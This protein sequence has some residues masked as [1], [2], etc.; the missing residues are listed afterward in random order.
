M[1][2][3]SGTDTYQG[4]H[5]DAAASDQSLDRTDRNL[6]AAEPLTALDGD[7][8]HLLDIIS[9]V[10]TMVVDVT[11]VR[12][13]LLKQAQDLLASRSTTEG[14]TVYMASEAARALEETLHRSLENLTAAFNQLKSLSVHQSIKDASLLAHRKGVCHSDHGEHG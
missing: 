7:A 6:M 13:R 8:C 2:Q 5:R 12:L 10:A 1:S 9:R 14:K 3:C 4:E 11:G